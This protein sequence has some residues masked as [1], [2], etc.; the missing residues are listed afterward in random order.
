M[1][2]Q[3][4]LEKCRDISATQTRHDIF[5]QKTEISTYRCFQ[6]SL[7]RL[8]FFILLVTVHPLPQPL[9]LGSG[10]GALSCTVNAADGVF[11]PERV[12]S[13]TKR[14]PNQNLITP[15]DGTQNGPIKPSP[16]YLGLDVPNLQILKIGDIPGMSTS[17]NMPFHN[18]VSKLVH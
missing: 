8:Q 15:S 4:V 2:C 10:L 17:S 16:T 12:T 5:W 3:N 14:P 6:L 7:C 11:F 18:H 1:S 13:Q 9:I